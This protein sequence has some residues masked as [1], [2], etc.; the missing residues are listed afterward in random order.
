MQPQFA[1]SLD[2]FR[3]HLEAGRGHSAHTVKAYITDLL[4]LV[5]F[6]E[7]DGIPVPSEIDIE[8]LRSWLFSLSSAGLAKSSLARK[9]ASA[10]AYTAWLLETGV[11]SH[12]PG[13]RLRTPKAD[14]HLPKVAS[15]QAMREVFEDLEARASTK[16][17]IAIRDLVIVELLYAT[18]CRVSELSGLNLED[19][20]ELRRLIRVTGKGNKQRMIPY[21]TP[22]Q[23]AIEKWL[24][25]GRGALTTEKTGQELLLNSRGQRLGTRQIFEVVARA[26]A[27][28]AIGASGPHALRHTAATHL[29]DGGA[30]LRAVQELLGH[31]S[32]G[33]TQI[34]THVSIERL[35]ASYGSAHPR[36]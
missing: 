24:R 1:S 14:K 15:R 13:L 32:L 9:T 29:L 21:G 34:Y 36:A 26:L 33:T 12:D 7:T 8:G 20:D 5:E 31:A 22:A 11:I 3:T 35:K 18:G 10:R 27:G 4:D 25:Q 17:P 16:D 23:G 2:K 19:I 30:D 6:L 28:T